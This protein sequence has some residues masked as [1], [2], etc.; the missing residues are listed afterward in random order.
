MTTR[1]RILIACVAVVIAWTGGWSAAPLGAT[2]DKEFQGVWRTVEVVVPGAPGS[3]SQI[4]TPAATLA[5]FHGRHYSRVEV[6]TE[7][8]RTPL[9]NVATATADQL[10]AV[11]GPFIGEGGTF[12]VEGN[13]TITMHATVAKNPADMNAGATSTY[14][15]RRQGDLLLLTQVRTPAGPSPYPITVKLARVE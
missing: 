9:V 14:T 10:R 7:Q 6:H 11:W 4:L 8:P 2:P 15:Y 13:N 1:I 5:I 12:A 3:P